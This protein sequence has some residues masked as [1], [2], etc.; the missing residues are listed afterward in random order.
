[1]NQENQNN[2]DCLSEFINIPEEGK[3]A[4]EQ[5]TIKHSW[6]SIW[7]EEIKDFN[8]ICNNLKNIL[9]PKR[10][11]TKNAADEFISNSLSIQTKPAQFWDKYTIELRY[12]L[13]ALSLRNNQT[14]YIKLPYDKALTY[15]QM[16]LESKNQ[17]LITSANSSLIASCTKNL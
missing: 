9:N 2:R 1:M 12:Q 15:Y 16:A 13:T 7:D 10:P 4:K 8:V 11:Y 14:E 17:D 3:M 5:I 6:D